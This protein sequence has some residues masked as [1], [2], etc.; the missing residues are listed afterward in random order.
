MNSR[1]AGSKFI[2]TCLVGAKDTNSQAY[3]SVL[4]NA[5]HLLE[6]P[7]EDDTRDKK[8]HKKN[9]IKLENDQTLT[10]KTTC[11]LTS[12]HTTNVK[13]EGVSTG[14]GSSATT[15]SEL[16]SDTVLT[17]LGIGQVTDCFGSSATTEQEK[18]FRFGYWTISMNNTSTDDI[19]R[20]RRM[21]YSII[22]FSIKTRTTN[23]IK[24]VITKTA[25]GEQ[26]DQK[27]PKK[28]VH[29]FNQQ[30]TEIRRDYFDKKK[31]HLFKNIKQNRSLLC[32]IFEMT[33]INKTKIEI[34]DKNRAKEADQWRTRARY[35]IKGKKKLTDTQ[36][37]KVSILI[38]EAQGIFNE[39][40]TDKG[41]L[42]KLKDL[43]VTVKSFQT[44]KK[45][46]K[47]KAHKYPKIR[48]TCFLED[49][50][51]HHC[52]AVCVSFHVAMS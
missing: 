25:L 49:S 47:K 8:R 22:S 45:Q 3:E 6:R 24:D 52:L 29:A 7:P 26:L 33:T 28:K 30:V 15:L 42:Q 27:T 35:Y 5:T 37:S 21:W 36:K 4:T 34:T 44:K 2:K 43:I 50:C 40:I 11:K 13:E 41:L 17:T 20:I 16:L 51:L 48:N 10:I 19:A 31:A 18:L 38:Q 39:K 1:F 14:V 12:N 46:K 23:S 32:K 9:K